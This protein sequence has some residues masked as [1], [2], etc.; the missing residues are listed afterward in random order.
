AVGALG[1][2]MAAAGPEARKVDLKGKFLMPGMID[3]H[4][5]PIAGGVT[6]IQANFPDTND[7]I[8]ALVQFVAD[9]MKTKKSRL[10]D[11][12]VVNGI[13]IGYW[14]H[15]AEIDAALS[16]GAFAKQ[17]IVLFGSDGHTAWANRPARSRAGITP[18]YLKSLTPEERRHFGSDAALHPNGFTV[19]AGKNKLDQSLPAPSA[20]SML[21]AGR[22]A[23]HYMNSLGITGWLDAAAAGVVGGVVPLSVD[24]PGYLPVYQELSQRGEL[25]AHVAAYPVVQPDLGNQ[26]IDV[27][28]ALR[29]RYKGI[30]NLT[31]PGLKV[32][33]DG[34]VEIPSQTAAMTKP[35]VNT[36]HSTA[37]MFTPA[38]MNALVSEAYRRGLTVHVH[39]IGDLAVKE[40]LD[41]FEAARKANPSST[42][43]FVLTHAQFVDPQDIPRFAKLHVIAALQLLWAIADQSTN[44][45]V[46]P[47]I[48]PAIYPWMYPARSLLD[49]GAV[50]AGA[51]DWPVSTADPFAATYQAE[52]RS[53]PQGVLNSAQRMPRQAMLY[54]YTRH[55]ALALNQ[56]NEI[57]SLAP[58]K[59]ADLALIDRDVLT[60]PAEELKGAKVLFTMF[61]GKIVYGH[62]P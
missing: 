46:K 5:H 26:Q 12:L 41:A 51:S 37:A 1:D 30:E 59:R 21:E 44:E 35:Y 52:T 23:V 8:P 25:T 9:L 13:D 3:A 58:G 34:V 11:V 61:G 36:G 47:Y 33:A 40:T 14:S 15:A 20:E 10:G 7:S 53:G 43:P 28:E 4:A 38:K 48:D 17:P 18:K 42:L 16:N 29:D 55:A 19:D 57:G 2:V 39:A 31:I 60:V 6:L 32:F 62:E 49:A 50:I 22:A 56:L 27:V 24:A 45:Q 54:A